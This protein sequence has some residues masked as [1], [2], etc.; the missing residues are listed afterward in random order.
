MADAAEE[1]ENLRQAL[2][3]VN[4]DMQQLAREI[5]VRHAAIAGRHVARHAAD[6]T[7]PATPPRSRDPRTAAHYRQ[8]ALGALNQ[9]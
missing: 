1:Q 4:D 6:A 8:Q 7:R 5:D 3:R 2:S 9:R